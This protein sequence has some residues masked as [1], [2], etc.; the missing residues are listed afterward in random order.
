MSDRRAAVYEARYGFDR[1]TVA[2]L[3]VSVLFCA[4]ALIPG[5]DFSLGLQIAIF[6]LFGD[7]GLFMAA[8]AL[9]RKV[10]F[11]V[12]ESGVLLGGSPLR[13]RATTVHVPWEDITAVVLWQQR[14]P[15]TT[16]PWVG[17]ARPEGAPPLPGP[18]QGRFAHAVG[19]ALAPVPI[20]LLVASRAV[21]GWRLDNGRLA[22][23]L[24]HFAPGVELVDGH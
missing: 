19:E 3:A 21:N 1:R 9:T 18:G 8:G 5:A 22:A 17:V 6:V 10:A 15:H 11:R 23:A 2:V 14:V 4:G 20:D 7:G 13:Y 24:A 12:D 16:I